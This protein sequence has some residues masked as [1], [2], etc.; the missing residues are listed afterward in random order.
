[1]NSATIASVLLAVTSAANKDEIPS[2]LCKRLQ[3]SPWDE[4][5][6]IALSLVQILKSIPNDDADN[7]L[8]EFTRGLILCDSKIT[9]SGVDKQ[10][11]NLSL[12]AQLVLSHPKLF[13]RLMAESLTRLN[14]V[15]SIAMQAHSSS[16]DGFAVPSIEFLQNIDSMGELLGQA[17]QDED[18][19]E[20]YHKAVSFLKFLE[21]ALMKGSTGIAPDIPV[22]KLI[23]ILLA[24]LGLHNRSI[25]HKAGHVLRLL[26]QFPAVEDPTS[27]GRMIYQR[28]QD[29]IAGSVRDRHEIFTLWL[30]WVGMGS[31]G[32]TQEM[33][34]QDKYWVMLQKGILNGFSAQRKVCLWILNSSINL[35]EES[36]QN[37]HFIWDQNARNASLQLWKKYATLF[38]I[39]VLDTSANQL[40][41]ALPEFH[42]LLSPP[43]LIHSSWLSALL[44]LALKNSST[45]IQSTAYGLILSLGWEMAGFITEREDWFLIEYFLP[46]AMIAGHFSVSGE[47]NEKCEH[48][49]AFAAFIASVIEH[50]SDST[51]TRVVET[52][53]SYLIDKHDV[54]FC[55]ARLYLLYGMVNGIRGKRILGKSQMEKIVNVAGMKRFSKMRTE[56]S[57]TLCLHLLLSVNVSDSDDSLLKYIQCILDVIKDSEH[58][59]GLREAASLAKCILEHQNNRHTL[60]V[61]FK[62]SMEIY[63]TS[64]GENSATQ[65]P[66]LST[67]PVTRQAALLLV[68]SY[69]H[70]GPELDWVQTMWSE[71]S[72]GDFVEISR[73]LTHVYAEIL[74]FG[75]SLVDAL[76]SNT[77]F[78]N[79]L[80]QNLSVFCFRQ[81]LSIMPMSTPL[82]TRFTKMP[83]ILDRLC[84][85][86]HGA[87]VWDQMRT[88][89]IHFFEVGWYAQRHSRSEVFDLPHERNRGIMI[90][91]CKSA[92]SILSKDNHTIPVT[93]THVLNIIA[94]Y[95][96]P[97]LGGDAHENTEICRVVGLAL[98][99]I[100]DLLDI[101]LKKDKLNKN[102]KMRSG[103]AQ[104]RL[105][106]AVFWHLRFIT[107]KALSKAIRCVRT[108][109]E[110]AKTPFKETVIANIGNLWEAAERIRSG[111]G[112]RAVYDEIFE[113]LFELKLK[114]P[115]EV[116]KVLEACDISQE[117]LKLAISRRSIA[118]A[119][120]KAIT[121]LDYK[122]LPY[123]PDIIIGLINLTQLKE[124]DYLQEESLCAMFDCI[125]DSEPGTYYQYYNGDKEIIAH[126]RVYDLLCKLNP[127]S[128]SDAWL[129]NILIDE[130][131][132]PWR[133]QKSGTKVPTAT[134]RTSQLQALLLLERFVDAKACPSFMQRLLD[135][136]NIETHPRYRFL[137]EWILARD[138]LRFPKGVDRIWKLLGPA[139]KLSPR[140]QVSLIRI[141]MMVAQG[142]TQ[143]KD[144]YFRKLI[145]NIVPFVCNGKVAVR[146]LAITSVLAICK[147]CENMSYI[148]HSIN[149]LL[150]SIRVHILNSQFYLDATP[151]ERA[152]CETP[153][154]PVTN[155]TLVGIFH[156][157]YLLGGD[158]V[159]SLTKAHFLTVDPNRA[160]ND[161]FVPLGSEEATSAVPSAVEYTRTVERIVTGGSA[162][163]TTPLQ[164]KS[165]AWTT[166]TNVSPSH[167]QNDS[168]SSSGRVNPPASREKDMLILASLIQNPTNLGGLSRVSEIFGCSSLAISSLKTI[169]TRDFTSVS[170][171]SEHWLTIVE[172]KTDAIREFIREKKVEG[173]IIVGIEQ[174]D[175]SL[176]LGK[177]QPVEDITN[178][179]VL[180]KVS[181]KEAGKA[182]WKLPKKA[183]LMLGSEREGI[184]AE[185]LGEVDLCVEI[186]QKGE[187]RSLNVQTAAAVVCYEWNRHWRQ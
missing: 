97:K 114:K 85:S 95:P 27:T 8:T 46:Y 134:K 24:L 184:P 29:I 109:N 125:A 37:T 152:Q 149:T 122:Y 32:P 175:K 47:H 174:T 173:Y 22:E 167:Q 107:T 161:H 132:E 142:I 19:H 160:E 11:A 110:T 116:E 84:T 18:M 128:E 62:S 52:L 105:I 112:I 186:E 53:L 1:M 168:S 70:P 151:K 20:V 178:G 67:F 38:E 153:F 42:R 140:F 89:A 80:V 133:E 87:D 170:V 118:P 144:L 33:L 81:K 2:L 111:T 82:D 180:A 148:E 187:T 73:T 185:L 13:Q 141:A 154:N 113:L 72:R 130:L 179:A 182:E 96:Q 39:I 16:D 158:Y 181:E 64:S 75:E 74:N 60:E 171:S 98:E 54:I 143:G 78:T 147:E 45:A 12:A 3:Q 104:E 23:P 41:D 121:K 115:K 99:S 101:I 145:E 77:E 21:V 31:H 129:A 164:T 150:I 66:V 123:Y 17:T 49:T 131:L 146:H 136:L 163:T 7:Y 56:L 124:V 86:L 156:G 50:S 103:D 5:G 28:L 44:A 36:F 71:Y 59:L 106:D 138:I 155:Y 51:A 40:K 176:V 169:T 83:H 93:Q 162:S 92:A 165:G 183:V 94:H 177:E 76:L 10:S 88:M 159:P 15:L 127:T 26:L 30:H 79:K 25:A 34:R 126:A 14:R 172:V 108:V 9:T 135:I 120:S 102:E 63:T 157:N 65:G 4:K 6:P 119:L 90:A 48:G 91:L 117:A 61:L 43:A 100:F 57:M 68:L 139:E 137:F 69:A 58:I 55:P 166:N 35:L